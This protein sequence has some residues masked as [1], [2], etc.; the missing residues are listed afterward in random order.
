MSFPRKP[1]RGEKSLPTSYNF[2]KILMTFA[3]CDG[4]FEISANNS[5]WPCCSWS[6]EL[7]FDPGESGGTFVEICEISLVSF[8][9]GITRWKVQNSNNA[10]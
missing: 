7:P 4:C 10:P 2:D 8:D 5:S 9:P 3:V 6:S 1:D